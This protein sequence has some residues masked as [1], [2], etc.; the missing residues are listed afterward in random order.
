VP[1]Q[2][3]I[4]REQDHSIASVQTQ[5][6]TAKGSRQNANKHFQTE[7]LNGS[8]LYLLALFHRFQN[9]SCF[10]NN[11]YVFVIPLFHD[12]IDKKQ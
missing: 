3:N 2:N 10:E 9:F 7:E 8:F 5:C 4:I 12:D 11:S 1:A 6:N